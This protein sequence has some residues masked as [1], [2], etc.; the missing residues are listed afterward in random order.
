VGGKVTGSG[1]DSGGYGKWIEVQLDNGLKAFVG[2][3]SEVL[4][5]AGQKFKAGQ[6][7]AATGNTGSSTG[8]HAHVGNANVGNASD[9]YLRFGGRALPGAPAP[10]MPTSAGTGTGGLTGASTVAAA[11]GN[12]SAAELE[13]KGLNAELVLLEGNTTKLRESDVVTFIN[14]NTEAFR[15]QTKTLG[16][17]TAA[18]QLRT[19]LEM[20]GVAPELVDAEI[21]K[22]DIKKQLSDKEKVL[23]ELTKDGTLTNN[24]YAASLGAIQAA[25]SGVATAVTDSANAALNLRKTQEQQAKIQD[26]Y[27]GI[28]NELTN[29]VVNGLVLAASATDNL[30]ESMKRLGSEVAAALGKML[31]IQGITGIFSSLGGNKNDGVGFFS[32]LSGGIGKRAAGGPIDAGTPYLVGEQGPELV[33]P[34]QSGYVFNARET[35]D[36]F[37]EARRALSGRG[38]ESETSVFNENKDALTTI[39]RNFETR[40][41]EASQNNLA[42]VMVEYRGPTL[43]FNGDDYLPKDAAVGI[44]EEASRRG[45]QLGQQRTLGL[46]KNNPAA[47]RSIG[48]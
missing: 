20:E 32:M 2:H 36:A 8:P 9:S 34:K 48:I 35:E 41:I 15:E 7:L 29:G 44:I 4:M 45:A 3:L 39:S 21:Q 14:K 10:A 11:L 22:L 31:L 18:I 38:A 12:V 30:G 16:E 47:R 26:F 19:R 24:E 33:L 23:L 6:V 1:F 46:L 40:V 27:N 17:Q 5:T 37:S 13:L 25:A 43:T 42:P 28:G